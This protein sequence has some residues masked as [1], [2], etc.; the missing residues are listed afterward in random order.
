MTGC[1][2]PRLP[3]TKSR[4]SHERASSRVQGRHPEN[5][6]LTEGRVSGCTQ[7]NG[8]ER[9][10]P[11]SEPSTVISVPSWV[12]PFCCSSPATGRYVVTRGSSQCRLRTQRKPTAVEGRR[13]ADTKLKSTSAEASSTQSHAHYLTRHPLGAEAARPMA[14]LLHFMV[15]G[16]AVSRGCRLYMMLFGGS[17][18]DVSPAMCLICPPLYRRVIWPTQ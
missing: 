8:S 17:T 5:H 2:P 10:R 11:T 16:R 4:E 14:R 15:C 1:L 7:A 3:L 9:S 12:L 18:S 13:V 6:Q